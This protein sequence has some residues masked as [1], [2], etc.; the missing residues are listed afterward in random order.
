MAKK[1]HVYWNSYNGPGDARGNY[2][3]YDHFVVL[4]KFN[5]PF[6]KTAYQSQLD[7][8]KGTPGGG[9]HKVMGVDD[10]VT[11]GM[12]DTDFFIPD[13]ENTKLE[14]FEA[15]KFT[16]DAPQN[17]QYFFSVWAFLEGEA[18]G[19]SYYPPRLDIQ[20]GSGEFVENNQGIIVDSDLDTVDLSD[21]L[22]I[23][24]LTVAG[25]NGK[26]LEVNDTSG[27]KDSKD[28]LNNAIEIRNTPDP[29]FKF[30]ATLSENGST[31]N[32]EINFKGRARITIRP[33]SASNIPSPNIFYEF[34]DVDIGGGPNESFTFN[35]FYNSYIA[36][37]NIPE[38]QK[39]FED[40]KSSFIITD[41]LTIDN[42]P[43]RH[44]DVVVEG[45]NSETLKTS[46]GNNLHD[47]VKTEQIGLEGDFKKEGIPGYDICEVKLLAPEGLIFLQEYSLRDGFVTPQQAFDKKIPYII[48]PRI[49]D[50][51]N[52]DLI[53]IRSFKETESIKTESEIIDEFIDP[54]AGV[55]VYYSD[56]PFALNTEEI[57]IRDGFEQKVTVD[58]KVVTVKREFVLAED[59]NTDKGDHI[60]S[61][62][63]VDPFARKEIKSQNIIIAG[64]DE[65]LY[66][67]HFVNDKPLSEKVKVDDKSMD[68]PTIL[69]EKELS[70]SQ[71]V[72]G[73]NDFK[74]ENGDSTNDFNKA[75][76]STSSIQMFKK[77]PVDEGFRAQS[78]RCYAYIEFPAGSIDAVGATNETS[79]IGQNNLDLSFNKKNTELTIN[80]REQL[81]YIP[82]ILPY[83]ESVDTGFSA[84]N[85]SSPVDVRLGQIDQNSAKILISKAG[86]SEPSM[87][88]F[89]GF[90]AIT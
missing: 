79:I 1:I 82:V 85:A 43:L 88:L 89:V 16:F 65:L 48:E 57:N 49:T 13:E 7:E 47:N 54:L 21:T 81:D 34:Y 53:F 39:H 5:E 66:V 29:N 69:G 51:G 30:F 15:Y 44:F 20:D 42:L 60:L 18:Y 80:F 25:S 71:T 28:P 78:Y 63:F 17:G 72:P 73:I 41:K 61:I 23:Y 74:D 67:K 62:P 40:T 24:G 10:L 84:V 27:E 35:S 8:T 26:F 64:F 11:Q 9:D 2:I 36:L 90:L 52:I 37:G 86:K 56:E 68:V 4:V 87:K 83:I 77:A 22:N 75:V 14:Q 12:E 19:P 38:G 33:P 58:D 70:F 31:G 76:K 50:D 59:F 6:T 46:A 3:E 55:V 32:K 45:Y